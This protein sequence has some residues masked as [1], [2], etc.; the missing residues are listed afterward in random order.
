VDI[1]S[2][3]WISDEQNSPWPEHN[4]NGQKY[5]ALPAEVPCPADDSGATAQPGQ[6][7]DYKDRAIVVSQIQAEMCCDI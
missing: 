2:R 7:T 6:G 3:E 1:R 5:T 4:R